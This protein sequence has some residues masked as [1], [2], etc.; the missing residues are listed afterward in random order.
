MKRMIQIDLKVT[1]GLYLAMVEQR[2]NERGPLFKR[3]GIIKFVQIDS[4]ENFGIQLAAR[5]RM[6]SPVK[7]ASGRPRFPKRNAL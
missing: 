5:R 1:A 7:L 3:L 4:G 2:F 6:R